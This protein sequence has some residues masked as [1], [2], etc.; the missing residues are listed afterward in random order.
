MSP[1]PYSARVRGLFAQ[2]AHA[3]SLAKAPQVQ[4]EDQGVRVVLA[5]E[6][7]GKRI[8]VLRFRAYG[9]PHLIAAAEALC[10]HYE[11][12]PVAALEA[13]EAADLVRD[14]PVPA[15]KTGRILV[16]EDAARAL[17]KSLRSAS[18]STSANG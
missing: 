4:I 5:G 10:E 18:E 8:R 2:P 12:R 11:G 6:A 15:E 16:L 17:G 3:G 1:D 9:C 14:L 13:F 7:D